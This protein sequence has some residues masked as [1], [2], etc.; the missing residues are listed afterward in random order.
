[1]ALT[2]AALQDGIHLD[3]II[4]ASQGEGHQV[5]RSSCI[6]AGFIVVLRGSFP[7]SFPA[8]SAW[9]GDVRR[10]ALGAVVAVV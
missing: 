8:A 4:A 7:A 1:M 6:A 10:A 2:L 9:L 3:E 5:D